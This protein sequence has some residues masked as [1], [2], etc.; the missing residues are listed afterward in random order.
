MMRSF[1]SVSKAMKE[2]VTKCKTMAKDPTVDTLLITGERGIGKSMLARTI[3]GLRKKTSGVNGKFV[4][5]ECT[6]ISD[7]LFESQL[8]GHVKGAFTGANY[9]KVGFVETAKNGTLFFDEIGD[10][11]PANQGKVLRLLQ[12]KQFVKVGSNE[13]KDMKVNLVIFATN[14]NLNELMENDLFRTDLYDRMKPPPLQIP[15]LKDRK[16]EIIALA[17]H[18]LIASN[19]N[20]YHSR[21]C[22]TIF[23][24]T[25]LG[26]QCA[27][28]KKYHHESSD[29]LYFK[30]NTDSRSS[31]NYP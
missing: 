15:S 2:I 17:E 25:T 22:Q 3:H 21:G 18:F 27:P 10:L 13:N 26:R 14:K 29:F 5:V 16:D 11:S 24:G 12:D 31:E 30:G 8:F 23:A 6:S 20:L 4:T 9:E 1:W 19:S 7:E 28:V